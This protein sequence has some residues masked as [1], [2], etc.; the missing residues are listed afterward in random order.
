MEAVGVGGFPV[1]SVLYL[2]T[3]DGKILL[4]GDSAS[5]LTVQLG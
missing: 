2:M 3:P 5:P 4:D 1:A